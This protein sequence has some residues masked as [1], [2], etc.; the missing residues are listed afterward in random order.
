MFSSSRPI[1]SSA[2]SF[3]F[4]T[5]AGTDRLR[6]VEFGSQSSPTPLRDGIYWYVVAQKVLNLLLKYYWCLARI[7]EPPYCPID[8]IIIE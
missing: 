5:A 2:R 6:V 1:A 8:R 4:A 7:P 3:R